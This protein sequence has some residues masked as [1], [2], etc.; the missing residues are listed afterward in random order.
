LVFTVDEAVAV[1]WEIEKSE[2]MT[3]KVNISK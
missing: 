2:K 3:K 1:S